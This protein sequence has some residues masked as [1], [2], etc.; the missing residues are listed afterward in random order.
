[1]TGP[2]K[3]SR[4]G[5]PERRDLSSPSGYLEQAFHL[6]VLFFLTNHR[7]PSRAACVVY[8]LTLYANA[9]PQRFRPGNKRFQ[10]F[11][12]EKFELTALSLRVYLH[13]H[14]LCEWVSEWNNST[15]SPRVHSYL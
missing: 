6:P 9:F 12:F 11:P 14:S 8:G 15:V 3:A 7:H 5:S 10:S 4:Q 1:M 13:T 2:A